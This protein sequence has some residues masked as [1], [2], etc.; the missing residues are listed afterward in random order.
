[1]RVITGR[2]KGRRLKAPKG[3]NTRP[4]TDRVKES[5]FCLL[6]PRVQGVRFLDLFAGSGAIGIEA[7][8]RGASEA[9]FID[10]DIKSV[11]IIKDNLRTT[12]LHS[13]AKVFCI[14]IFKGLSVLARKEERFQMI[15]LDPPYEKGFEDK[16]LEFIA[17]SKILDSKGLVVVESSK[18]TELAEDYSELVMVRQETYGDSKINFFERKEVK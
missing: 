3:K 15:F 4:T 7:L 5:L 13:E 8:S 2:A 17:Q 6:G 14:D 16:I 12:D 10:S 11:E 9:I 1:M 18:R